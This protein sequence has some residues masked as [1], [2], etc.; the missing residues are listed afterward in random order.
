LKENS[1]SELQKKINIFYHIWTNHL[2]FL[3]T[4]V[5]GLLVAG[6]SSYIPFL[7]RNTNNYFVNHASPTGLLHINLNLN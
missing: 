1:I 3:N 6:L 5:T 4:D 2:D 7:G